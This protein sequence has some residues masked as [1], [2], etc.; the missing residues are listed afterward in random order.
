[1]KAA[2]AVLLAVAMLASGCVGTDD[3]TS[4][5]AVDGNETDDDAR[6][7]SD[8]TH[9]GPM[10]PNGT[11][12]TT[13]AGYTPQANATVQVDPSDELQFS[14]P[15]GGYVEA[16]LEVDEETQIQGRAYMGGDGEHPAGFFGLLLV[17]PSEGS[18]GQAEAS[19]GAPL[20]G[21]SAWMAASAGPSRGNWSL[22]EGSHLLLAWGNG[23][24]F[25]LT[26]EDSGAGDEPR[27]I[28]PAKVNLTVRTA[29]AEVET[30]GGTGWEAS[31]ETGVDPGD[32]TFLGFQASRFPAVGSGS[33]ESTVTS[34]D[35]SEC[36]S[37]SES[38]T[39]VGGASMSISFGLQGGSGPWQWTGSASYQ[40]SPISVFSG[41]AEASAVMIDHPV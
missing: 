2:A 3:G 23:G 16:I 27:E 18:A 34:E 14:V 39:A 35:G 8:V 36:A 26:F 10:G 11:N 38:T 20:D 9:D 6:N 4:P 33:A 21:V 31:F 24:N 1:M 13:Y 32:W 25:T 19:C 37:D 22:D 30:S 28:E 7:E 40:V 29:D 17:S 15:S 12:G 41:D 5:S